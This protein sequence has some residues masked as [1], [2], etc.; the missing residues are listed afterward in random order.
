VA[1][2][3]TEVIFNLRVPTIVPPGAARVLLE[4]V[5]AAADS[6]PDISAP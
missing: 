3:A 2:G 1:P 6:E 5:L 4:I